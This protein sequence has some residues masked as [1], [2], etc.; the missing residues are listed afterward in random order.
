M[1]KIIDIETGLWKR[2]EGL[3]LL[4][5]TQPKDFVVQL[6]KQETD[7]ARNGVSN[8]LVPVVMFHD[9][10]NDKIA[11]IK[12]IRKITGLELKDAKLASESPRI[13]E[14]N[15]EYSAKDIYDNLV[16]AGANVEIKNAA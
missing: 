4:L 14:G 10:G 2:V 15:E 9:C 7:K 6:L 8:L 13:F 12:A 16:A 11:T 3:A 1:R 5:D